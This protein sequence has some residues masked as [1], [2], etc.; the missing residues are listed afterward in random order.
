MAANRS[1]NII[2]SSVQIDVVNSDDSDFLPDLDC[3]TLDQDSPGLGL[4]PRTET[5]DGG[6]DKT[7]QEKTTAGMYKYCNNFSIGSCLLTCSK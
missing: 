5:R 6:V 7:S 1:L 2:R 3:I 4:R